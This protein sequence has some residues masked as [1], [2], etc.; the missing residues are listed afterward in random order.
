M[1]IVTAS[2][3]NLLSVVLVTAKSATTP[4]AANDKSHDVADVVQRTRS[5]DD[6]PAPV[7][8]RCSGA[9]TK[10]TIVAVPPDSMPSPLP[11]PSVSTAVTATTLTATMSTPSWNQGSNSAA[12]PL[13][14]YA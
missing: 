6:S 10:A 3:G 4:G 11:L 8:V 2:P 7:N 13:L 1:N 12:V 5:A 14:R 9:P